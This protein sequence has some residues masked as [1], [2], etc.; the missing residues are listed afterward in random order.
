MIKIVIN[1]LTT[2]I[3]CIKAMLRRNHSQQMA[4]QSMHRQQEEHREDT[5]KSL[6]REKMDLAS[7]G[8]EERVEAKRMIRMM[9]KEQEE[10]DISDAIM[11]TEQQRQIKEQQMAQDEAL[12]TELE[13]LKMETMRDEKMR[14]QIRANRYNLTSYNQIIFIYYNN[15]QFHVVFQPRTQRTRSIP[16]SCLHEQRTSSTTSRERSYSA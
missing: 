15:V 2:L 4:M 3:F 12:A 9:K 5:L 11:H 7:I 1:N 8:S 14:Q 6:Q 16:E 13:R 10:K